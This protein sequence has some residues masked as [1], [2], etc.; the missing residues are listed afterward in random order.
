MAS[1]VATCRG[2][3]RVLRAP[4]VLRPGACCQTLAAGCAAVAHS[5]WPTS[6]ELPVLRKRAADF[7]APRRSCHGIPTSTSLRRNA[8]ASPTRGPGRHAAPGLSTPRDSE[9]PA[10]GR[11]ASPPA[12]TLSHSTGGLPPPS[13]WDF[14]AP[15]CAAPAAVPSPTPQPLPCAVWPMWPYRFAIRRRPGAP[16]ENGRDYEQRCRFEHA[17]HTRVTPP[18]PAA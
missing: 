12:D 16:S 18:A 5:C 3:G 1:L 4:R 10:I 17:G 2:C 13:Y 6:L 7:S 15:S 11:R 8:S 9:K 14:P